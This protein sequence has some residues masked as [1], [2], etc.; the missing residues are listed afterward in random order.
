MYTTKFNSK[1]TLEEP[2]ERTEFNR[3][4]PT[5]CLNSLKMEM[6]WTKN[7]Y[8]NEK[9]LMSQLG[10]SHPG[11]HV[12]LYGTPPVPLT[13]VAPFW[14]GSW[15]QLSTAAKVNNHLSGRYLSILNNHLMLNFKMVKET[16]GLTKEVPRL[17]VT[18]SGY[19]LKL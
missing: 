5:K 10:P 9:L 4:H 14:H 3:N 1:W 12:Q 11:T 2:I 16:L 19:N 6:H 8:K 7:N 18:C 13:H 15:T 17:T